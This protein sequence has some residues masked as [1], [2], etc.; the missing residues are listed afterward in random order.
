MA[1]RSAGTGVLVTLVTFVIATVGLLVVCI[2]QFS[3]SERARGEAKDLRDKLSQQ[4][5]A[6]QKL[7]V[8]HGAVA[9]QLTGSQDASLDEEKFNSAMTDLGVPAGGSVKSYV[10]SL[11]GKLASAEKTSAGLQKQV[12]ELKS[13]LQPAE[14]PEGEQ[15]SETAAQAASTI[16]QLNEAAEGY[17]RDLEAVKKSA[18]ETRANF[19]QR[20]QE[21]KQERDAEVEQLKSSKATL[22][23]RLTEANRKLSQFETQPSDPSLMV[24]GNVIQVGGGDGTVFIDLGRSHRVQPGMTFEVFST[25][26]Q[27]RTSSEQ[28]LRGK[29]TLQI[30]KVGDDTST[31]RVVRA[32]PGK[33]V[34]R[35]DVLANAVYSPTQR[36][37]FLVHGNFDLDGDGR[38][39]A[40]EAGI[41]RNRIREWGGVLAEGDRVTGDLDFVVIGSRPRRPAKPLPDADEAEL[42]AFTDAQN[43]CDLFEK[44]ER[45]A[46]EAR[47]PVLNLN[48]FE[49]LTGMTN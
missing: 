20:F 48:R 38:A 40:E 35:G 39:T 10:E 16:A 13:Q 11:K 46:T 25:A 37:R 5:Q 47:I 9:S 4:T 32:S 14:A 45:E 44:I 15:P 34:V 49:A 41:I 43:A 6:S 33:P 23:T 12:D 22:E 18:D 7:S 17:R 28:G 42:S 19:E 8:L 36:F 1:T 3:G 24:D 2:V 27:I 21:Y 26:D 31:A 30:M 29:A